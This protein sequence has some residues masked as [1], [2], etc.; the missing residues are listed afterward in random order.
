MTFLVKKK[1]IITK[2]DVEKFKVNSTSLL[3]RPMLDYPVTPLLTLPEIMKIALNTYVED[4]N[5]KTS[6][7]FQLPPP[8]MPGYIDE[9]DIISC[10]GDNWL[11]GCSVRLLL[12]SLFLL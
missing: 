9:S 6:I 4:I 11:T 1:G 5:S 8:F 10:S 7:Q 2:E 12:K 3:I